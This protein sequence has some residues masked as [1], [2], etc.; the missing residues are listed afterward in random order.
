MSYRVVKIDA[1]NNYTYRIEWSFETCE[2]V[3]R[4]LEFPLQFS[5]APTAQGAVQGIERNV[6]E[7]VA[8]LEACGAPSPE[9]ISDRRYSGNFVVRTSPQLHARLVVEA[10]EQGASLNHW[11]VQKLAGRNPTPSLDDLF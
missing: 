2:Y 7:V 11:V 9:S 3:G 5:N 10:S 8:D 6:A 1:V 4:C